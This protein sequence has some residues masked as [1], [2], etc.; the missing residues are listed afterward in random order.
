MHR[1]SLFLFIWVAAGCATKQP[2]CKPASSGCQYAATADV[3]KSAITSLQDADAELDAI[4]RNASREAIPA[5]Q[6]AREL[7][8]QRMHYCQT[9]LSKLNSREDHQDLLTA[10]SDGAI[11]M[12]RHLEEMFDNDRI[13]FVRFYDTPFYRRMPAVLMAYSVMTNARRAA[14]SQ[15][16]K[17]ENRNDNLQNCRFVK[18]LIGGK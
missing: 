2:V 7:V 13:E 15:C 3:L 10:G 12:A 9:L 4:S 11:S 8:Q 17:S 16:R 18:F 5:V 6:M 14:L 1:M